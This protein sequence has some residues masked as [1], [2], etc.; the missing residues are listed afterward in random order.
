MNKMKIGFDAKRIFFNSTGLGNYSRTLVSNYRQY[1][2]Q[3]NLFLFTQRETPKID[4]NFDVKGYHVIKGPNHIF[5]RFK[6]ITQEIEKHKINLYHGLSNELPMGI[7][8]IGKLKKVVTI[9][10]LIFMKFPEFYSLSDRYIYHEKSKRACRSADSIIAISESTKQDIIAFYGIPDKKI[11]VLYQACD[12]VFY[13]VEG[14]SSGLPE[15]I[16]KAKRPYFLFVGSHSK[17][18]NLISVIKALAEIPES[19]RPLLVISGSELPQKAKLNNLI[20]NHQL[21]RDIVF[22][23]FID[24]LSLKAVYENAAF[25][26]YPSLYEGFGLPIVEAMLSGTQVVTSNISSMPEA[27]LGGAHL[28]DPLSL[29]DIKSHILNVESFRKLTPGEIGEVKEKYNP[30]GLSLKLRDIYENL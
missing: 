20:S 4:I 9:H 13:S 27:A 3:E 7:Q 22:L 5:W 8:D 17:R 23:G 29:N 26:I 28:I 1:V 19:I 16:K 18:K 25:L 24:N 30:V 21:Q 14:N 11:E 12:D 2:Q 15:L 6:G 10:D